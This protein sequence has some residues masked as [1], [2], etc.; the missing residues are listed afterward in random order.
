MW[1]VTR[2]ELRAI[3]ALGHVAEAT[4]RGLASWDQADQWHVEAGTMP[5]LKPGEAG[6]ILAQIERSSGPGLFVLKDFHAFTQ[7]QQGAGLVRKLRNLSRTLGPK[8]QAIVVL[9]PSAELPPEL[10]DDCNLYDFPLPTVRELRDALATFVTDV[11]DESPPPAP[12]Q[13]KLAAAA[14]GLT[15][16]EAKV[17]FAKAR[18]LRGGR[19]D[20]E[21]VAHVLSEKARIIKATGALEFHASDVTMESVG[22]LWALKDWLA[23]RERAFGPTAR[24]YRLRRPRGVLVFGIPG[25][26]KSLIC[27][28]VASLWR[29]PL[30]RLDV[31]AVFGPLVGQSEENMRTATRVVEAIAPCVLWLD[32]VEKAFGQ[33]DAG[34]NPVHARVFGAFLTWMQEK[35]GDVF[36]VATAN[37]IEALPLEFTRKGRFDEV[38]FVDLPTEPEREEILRVH[39]KARRPILSP[40]EDGMPALASASDS[41]TGAEIEAAIDEAMYNAFGEEERDFTSQDILAA[42]GSI[43]PLAAAR[44][45]EVDRLRAWVQDGRARAASD[46]PEAPSEVA[47]P[48]PGTRFD[49]ATRG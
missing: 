41:Y 3:G 22:G 36:V 39:L 17:T 35:Q 37:Q 45:E 43:K 42:L 46:V 32:E 7:G 24:D 18:Y 49:R 15:L 14:A 30:V 11:G 33:G 19:L 5:D 10:R 21:A 4:N 8:Q 40:Y 1:L 9:T 29:W 26:G 27:K 44:P 23:K 13:A 38:F 25:T 16:N 12:L 31:G 47:R 20:E 28:A 34:L 48:M 2:E 6:A